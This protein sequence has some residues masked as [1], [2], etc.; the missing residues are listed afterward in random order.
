MGNLL[1]TKR[2]SSG[3]KIPECDT[4]RFQ[5][6]QSGVSPVIFRSGTVLRFEAGHVRL[7]DLVAKSRVFSDIAVHKHLFSGSR[8][9]D[10]ETQ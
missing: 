9:P 10:L 2:H 3:R 4:K 1:S 8:D 5:A 7:C 6:V